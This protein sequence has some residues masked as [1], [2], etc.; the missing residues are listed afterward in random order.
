MSITSELGHRPSS[1]FPG[2]LPTVGT[3]YCPGSQIGVATPKNGRGLKMLGSHFRMGVGELAPLQGVSPVD[4][5]FI[6]RI[7]KT[8]HAQYTAPI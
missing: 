6:K 3:A 5:I 2:P 4:T 8:T 7:E 1:L